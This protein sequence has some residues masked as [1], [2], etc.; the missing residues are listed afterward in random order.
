MHQTHL[1]KRFVSLATSSCSWLLLS[2]RCDEHKRG[3]NV[4]CIVGNCGP[5]QRVDV[6][7]RV[8]L[9]LAWIIRVGLIVYSSKIDFHWSISMRC[10]LA[11]F[12]ADSLR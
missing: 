7:Y 10:V 6:V 3:S 5:K 12:E 8:G 1:L 2:T 9:L 4:G 11:V